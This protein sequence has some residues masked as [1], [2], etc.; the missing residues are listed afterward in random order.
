MFVDRLEGDW[1]VCEDDDGRMVR[2]ARSA[3]DGPVREGDCIVIAE[4][5][6]QADPQATQER[7]RQLQERFG[8]LWKK[9]KEQQ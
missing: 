6:Y 2:I 3:F 7:R 8:G 9:R 4:G 5:R 1:V